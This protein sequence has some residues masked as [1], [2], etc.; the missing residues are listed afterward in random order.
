MPKPTNLKR[1]KIE[2][3]D[4]L[5][6][7]TAYIK[8]LSDYDVATLFPVQYIREMKERKNCIEVYVDFNI[9][10][11]NFP[12]TKFNYSEYQRYKFFYSVK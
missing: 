8:L 12:I 9:Q 7:K 11:Q 2:S 3:D 6:Q 4:F 1:I 10:P 5:F